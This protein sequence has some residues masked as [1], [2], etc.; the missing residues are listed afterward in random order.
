MTRLPP[1]PIFEGRWIRLV[2]FHRHPRGAYVE[3]LTAPENAFRFRGVGPGTPSAT[4]ERL[5]G[6]S[7]LVQFGIEA[8]DAHRLV[9]LVQVVAPD[10]RHGT[11]QMAL[12]LEPSSQGQGWPLEAAI[13]T[14]NYTLIAHP[15]RKVYFELP[16]HNAPFLARGLGSLTCEEGT[17]S[18]HEWIGGSYRDVTFYSIDR[19]SFYEIEL[20]RQ[21]LGLEA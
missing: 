1:G 9:G 10:F 14:L 21:L 5:L 20:V 15:L 16:A 13:L 2:P 19:S 17:L 12:A 18:A 4:L 7:V 11:A 8:I 3:I 6:D